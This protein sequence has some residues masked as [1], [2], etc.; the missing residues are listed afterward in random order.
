[1]S[2]DGY[3]PLYTNWPTPTNNFRAIMRSIGAEKRTR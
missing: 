1:V 3:L 2:F